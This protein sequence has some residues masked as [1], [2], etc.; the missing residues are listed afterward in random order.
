M[1]DIYSLMSYYKCSRTMWF[2]GLY[3]QIK[4]SLNVL[5]YEQKLNT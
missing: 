3:F 4:P 5:K 1:V 2:E